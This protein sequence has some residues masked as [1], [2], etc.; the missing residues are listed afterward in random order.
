MRPKALW[1]LV[2]DA[3]RRPPATDAE[4]LARVHA[5]YAGYREAFPAVAAIDAEE[6]LA[7]LDG[8][9][10]P[11]LVDVR[12][13]EEQAVS[14]LPGALTVEAF[15]A[16]QPPG[17][18]VTYCTI[19]ARS[20]EYAEQLRQAGRDVKNLAGSLLAWTHAGGPL[21]GADGATKRVHVYG[22]RWDLARSDYEGVW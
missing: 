21:V 1:A 11:V 8:E 14:T 3:L 13:P 15:E 6:L 5:M 9:A 20:G 22:R 4:R 17:P 10:P 18:V 12:S 19:G 7:A 16:V 2:R